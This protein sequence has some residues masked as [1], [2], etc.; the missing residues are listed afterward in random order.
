[1]QICPKFMHN[2]TCGCD[3]DSYWVSG[4]IQ[5]L[6]FTHPCYPWE[7]TCGH[8]CVGGRQAVG[9]PSHFCNKINWLNTFHE[10]F[11]FVVSTCFIGHVYIDYRVTVVVSDVGWVDSDL[12]DLW[13]VERNCSCPCRLMEHPISCQPNTGPW[14]PWSPC[15]WLAL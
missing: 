12:G 5:T 6:L 2:F 4:F 3:E 7:S 11:K 8:T 15:S 13:M 14:P 1:M 9:V 10:L